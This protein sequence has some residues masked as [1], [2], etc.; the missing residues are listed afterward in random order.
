MNYKRVVKKIVS[1]FN[2]L[3]FLK[4]SKTI[5][6]A[7]IRNILFISLYFRGDY[8]FHTVLIKLL[9]EICP[10]AKLDVWIKSHNAELAA[11]NPSINEVLVF[12]NIRISSY[13]DNSKIDLKGKHKFF[14]KIRN[15]KYDLVLD[16]TGKISTALFTYFLKAKYTAGINNYG[17]GA[18]YDKFIDLRPASVKGHL[19]KKYLSIAKYVFNIEDRKWN[20]LIS[21]LMLKPYIY[22]TKKEQ[23]KVDELLL[24][25]FKVNDNNPLV[26]IHPTAGW[27]A[28]EWDAN[29]YSILID[30]LSERR[31]KFLFIG[32]E[33]DHKIF[34]QIVINSKLKNDPDVLN[35][36]L[37]LKFLEVAEL[38]KRSDIF[39]GSDSVSLHLAG[40]VGTPSIGLFGPT[41]PEFSK[42]IGD[43]HRVIYH[44]LYCS[45][46]DVM[47]YCSRQGG[48]TCKTI[49]CMK[50]IKVEEVMN[51][52]E[53]SIYDKRREEKDKTT[54]SSM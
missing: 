15:R 18:C 51:L 34:K 8:L 46:T 44:K 28:K 13:N 21:G 20:E 10:D 9:K 17:F 5:E 25:L 16:I 38:I 40:A 37:K 23:L 4:Q 54:I 53:K 39:I 12:D 36:F 35:Y 26:I 48:M 27:S 11:N 24:S 33:K 47:Q 7:K 14:K 45:S 1:N 52:I 22:I 30:G 50:L 3:I 6:P 29:N 31:I 42:P 49:D 41:N 2:K 32:D 43:A 19:I